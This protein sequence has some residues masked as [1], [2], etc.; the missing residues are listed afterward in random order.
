M[1]AYRTLTYIT[2]HS[3]PKGTDAFGLP[4]CDRVELDGPRYDG[5]EMTQPGDLVPATVPE[6]VA[7]AWV[8]QGLAEYVENA[9]T[10]E[11][12]VKP[13]TMLLPIEHPP[14]VKTL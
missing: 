7:K 3:D 8:R 9:E 10:P 14:K 12:Q 4:I 5:K 2:W 13:P 1:G 6:A 11:E